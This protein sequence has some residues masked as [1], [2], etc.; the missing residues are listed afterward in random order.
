M[1]ITIITGSTSGIGFEVAKELA[2][3]KHELILVSRDLAKLEYAKDIITKENKIK[4]EIHQHDLSLIRENILFYKNIS[5]KYKNIDYLIN[6]VGAIFMNRHETFEG[7]E[8]TFSL[9]HMS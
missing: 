2:K 3:K 8:K 4:C 7:L 6:N 5:K 1:P 9:N